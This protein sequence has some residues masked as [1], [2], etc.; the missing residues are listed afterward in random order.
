M[1]P[2]PSLW[3]CR[4]CLAFLGLQLHPGDLCLSPH[5]D[6]PACLSVP[7]SLSSSGNALG[8]ILYL[9]LD[10]ALS[11]TGSGS[12]A[13]SLSGPSFISASPPEGSLQTEIHSLPP[14]AGPPPTQQTRQKARASEPGLYS[15]PRPGPF[16]PALSPVLLNTQNLRQQ[17]RTAW[18]PWP[19]VACFIWDI[20][21]SFFFPLRWG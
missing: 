21:F 10:L 1:I 9:F 3:G 17:S 19:R 11:F 16:L 2:P 8:P 18:R 4:P 6:L 7:A 12:L 15:S 14:P 13:S 20:Y 5:G